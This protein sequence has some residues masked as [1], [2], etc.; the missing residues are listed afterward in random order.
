MGKCIL[1]LMGYLVLCVGYAQGENHKAVVRAQVLHQGQALED[2]Q[3]TFSRSVAGRTAVVAGSGQTDVTGWTS[4]DVIMQSDWGYYTARVTD[5]FDREIGQWHSIP[6]VAG[7]QAFLRLS[8]GEPFERVESVLLHSFEVTLDSALTVIDSVITGVYLPLKVTAYAQL[9]ASGVFKTMVDEGYLG[10]EMHLSV[11]AGD[12]SVDGVHWRGDGVTDLGDGKAIVK[13]GWENGSRQIEVMSTRVLDDFD[14][15]VQA[16]GRRGQLSGLTVDEGHLMR[17]QVKALEEGVETTVVSGEFVVDVLPTDS[18]G[19]PSIKQHPRPWERD[20]LKL[21]Q[22]GLDSRIN[23]TDVLPEIFIEFGSNFGA[24]IIPSGAQSVPSQGARFTAVAPNAEGSGFIVSVRTVNVHG[25]TASYTHSVQPIG[26]TPELTFLPSTI[27]PAPTSDPP[28]APKNL[29]VQDYKGANGA[30]DQGGYVLVTFPI[31]GDHETVSHYRIDRELE[32]TTAQD[33]SG[34]VFVL[35]VPDK[36][37]VPWVK[38]DRADDITN[39]VRAIVP[40][41]DNKITRWAVAAEREGPNGV[42]VSSETVIADVA[43]GAVDNIAPTGVS[44]VKWVV[45]D[46][47]VHVSWDASVDDRTVGFINY[48]GFEAPIKG[49]V[50]YQVYR[51]FSAVNMVLIDTLPSG[52]TSYVDEEVDI[53]DI[54]FVR[55]RI[56]ALDLDNRTLTSHFSA[57][58]TKPVLFN[59]DVF[60][61][62]FGA[63]RGQAHYVLDADLDGDGVISFA[64][65]LLYLKAVGTHP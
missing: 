58:G 6:L 27:T 60:V 3:V 21:S 23:K 50:S 16:L 25:D 61:R 9:F 5:S 1:I 36:K 62:S 44:N 15:F 39:V 53:A 52:T 55:Y 56:D 22:K 12:Q 47:A 18:W 13:G 64:D 49:V 34:R 33:D 20:S 29:V 40:V 8:V 7:E 2:V 65:F 37:W 11:K 43:V 57:T 54:G 51:G 28:E 24:A 31:S 30:G 45:Q 41:T 46:G 63:K 32:I 48:R 10:E 59:S 35:E 14:V 38:L 26:A 19:N 4:V 17:F 42:M